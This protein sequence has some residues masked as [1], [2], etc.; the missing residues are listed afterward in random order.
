ML[1]NKELNQITAI[2]HLSIQDDNGSIWNVKYLNQLI[3]VRSNLC[4]VGVR[5]NSQSADQCCCKLHHQQYRLMCNVFIIKQSKSSQNLYI[6]VPKHPTMVSVPLI[7]LTLMICASNLI[8]ICSV[9]FY[10]I[11]TMCWT[12]FFHRSLPSRMV[13][14]LDL[15]HMIDYCPVAWRT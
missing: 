1:L 6:S 3:D 4:Q 8:K 12:A 7:Y 13:T 15:V 10:V 2:F 9:K 11:R 14:L 5:V